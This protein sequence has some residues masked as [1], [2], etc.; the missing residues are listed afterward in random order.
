MTQRA[1]LTRVRHLRLARTLGFFF[2]PPPL[3]ELRAVAGTGGER[4]KNPCFCGSKILAMKMAKIFRFLKAYKRT[5][6]WLLIFAYAAVRVVHPD[7][8]GRF[9]DL[10]FIALLVMLIACQ[11]FWIRRILDLG[12]RFRPGKYR[13]NDKIDQRAIPSSCGTSRC[14]A[15]TTL[16][17]SLI[18]LMSCFVRL[19]CNVLLH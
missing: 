19:G 1:W 10:F 5:I 4:G 7:E 11:L 14:A 8:D 6:V 15:S 12:E 3:C 9:F 17:Q 16:P 2:R 13:L 18:V